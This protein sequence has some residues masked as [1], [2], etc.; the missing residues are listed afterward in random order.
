M[1]SPYA[2]ELKV[3]TGLPWVRFQFVIFCVVVSHY[4]LPPL[5]NSFCAPDEK[6]IGWKEPKSLGTTKCSMVIS[7]LDKFAVSKPVFGR[8]FC[9]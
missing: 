2:C 1:K 9:L 8:L 3:V 4:S 6:N 7:L 5:S